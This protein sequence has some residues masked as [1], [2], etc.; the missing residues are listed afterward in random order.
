MMAAFADGLNAHGKMFTTSD[1]DHDTWPSTNCA[2]T[3][4]GGWWF[5]DCTASVVNIDSDGYWVTAK[6]PTPDVQE[7]HMLVKVN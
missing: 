3:Y 2:P 4:G 1:N 7:S 5:G 6:L